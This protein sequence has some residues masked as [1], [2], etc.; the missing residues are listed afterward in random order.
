MGD[1]DFRTVTVA[2]RECQTNIYQRVNVICDYDKGGDTIASIGLEETPQGYFSGSLQI[3][4]RT[5]RASISYTRY[6]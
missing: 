3:L 4:A 6:F 5:R 1:L 2:N